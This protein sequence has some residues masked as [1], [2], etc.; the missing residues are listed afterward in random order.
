MSEKTYSEHE[1]L[2][3]IQDKSQCVGEFLE[4]LGLKQLSVCEY[5]DPET[6]DWDGP[7]GYWP[8]RTT[9]EALLAEFFKIDT[10]KLEEEKVDMLATLQ[11]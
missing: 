5:K 6:S 3:K 11:Q 9:T 2:K 4:F 8:D 7:E 1:K 10:V